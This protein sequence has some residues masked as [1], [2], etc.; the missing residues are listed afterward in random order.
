MRR[1]RRQLVLKKKT[2]W[3]KS[4]NGAIRRQ[5]GGHNGGGMGRVNPGSWELE[6]GLHNTRRIGRYCVLYVLYYIRYYITY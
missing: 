4:V 3:E 2:S 6:A 1:S 5:R